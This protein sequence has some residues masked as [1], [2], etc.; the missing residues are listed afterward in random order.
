LALR[1]IQLAE[2]VTHVAELGFEL[3]NPRLGLSEFVLQSF[4]LPLGSL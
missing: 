1:Q 4:G 2:R 3:L